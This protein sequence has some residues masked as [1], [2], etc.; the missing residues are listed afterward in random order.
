MP[1]SVMSDIDDV[2]D[3]VL[4]TF[5][6]L[7]E[8][9]EAERE[10]LLEETRANLDREGAVDRRAF[11]M[12]VTTGAVTILASYWFCPDFLRNRAEGWWT[13]GWAALVGIIVIFAGFPKLKYRMMVRELWRVLPT[14]CDECG[15][16]IRRGAGQYCPGCGNEVAAG[17]L[18]SGLGDREA[19]M[20]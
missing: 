13:V 1:C 7:L 16:V 15:C 4:A 20:R 12:N 14:R 2:R 10:R 3:R 6:E 19:A 8:M 11:L 18:R 9:S 5:P 17:G